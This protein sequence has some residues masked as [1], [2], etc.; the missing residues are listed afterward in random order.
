MIFK[1]VGNLVLPLVTDFAQS[2]SMSVIMSD[3]LANIPPLTPDLNLQAVHPLTSTAQ[4]DAQLTTTST[5]A[6]DP[7]EPTLSNKEAPKSPLDSDADPNTVDNSV[8][9]H[10]APDSRDQSASTSHPSAITTN[11]APVYST[12]S[13]KALTDAAK[14]GDANAQFELGVRFDQGVGVPINHEDALKWYTQSAEQGHFK[15]QHNLALKYDSGVGV[16][17]D[18]VKA[19][20]WYKKAADQG[21]I[22]S[23]YNLAVLYQLGE[24]VEKNDVIAFSWFLCAAEQGHAV[25]QYELGINYLNGFGVKKNITTAARWFS[26]AADQNLPEAQFE[27]GNLYHYGFNGFNKDPSKGI[28]L[29]LKAANQGYAKAQCQ[30]GWIYTFGTDM[31]I[32]ISKDYAKAV[33]WL[34]LAADQDDL[35]GQESLGAMYQK[36]HGVKQSDEDAIIWYEKA[37]EQGSKSAQ[38]EVSLAYKDGKGVKKDFNRSV[39][40]QMKCNLN[41]DGDGDCDCIKGTF[42]DISLSAGLIK[43]IAQN[44]N[45]VSDFKNITKLVFPKN[46][47]TNDEFAGFAELI[48]ENTSLKKLTISTA[49]G[50]DERN[51][52]MLVQALESNTQLIELTV[53]YYIFELKTNEKLTA[54]LARNVA[55]AELRQYV[56]DYP[57]IHTASFALDPLNIIV[58]K[59]I[60]SY[61]INGASKE[62][63]KIAIDEL[64]RHAS[65]YELEAEVKNK[66]KQ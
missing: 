33:Y 41:D 9:E 65:V 39:Y 15:A 35:G 56:R 20:E 37:A 53:E 63:T 44:L 47:F 49:E 17:I 10:S 60:V 28:D 45:N 34:R 32:D 22:F 14:S 48:R 25:A 57:L 21:V 24:G 36:G 40:W 7:S 6:S 66:V 26:K 54:L 4:T 58:D 1:I 11:T 3:R 18:S 43:F 13:M 23:Q 50:I 62:E 64:L 46:K 51:F 55:I 42:I 38:H 59:T 16:K 52:L 2:F 19:A 61:M 30:L 8:L 12:L 27:L 29:Y 31:G 5:T